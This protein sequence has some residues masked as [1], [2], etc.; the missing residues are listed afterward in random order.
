MRKHMIYLAAG[1]S[2][3]FGA[4]KLLQILGGK[5]LY[6]YG[7]ELLAGLCAE[8]DD[9]TL[10]VV[11]RCAEILNTAHALGVRAVYG[12]DSE[13]GQSF[14]IR[15]GLTALGPLAGTDFVLFAVADQ[16]R[17]T[18]ATVARL[19]DAAAP[20]VETAVASFDG[21]AGSPALFAAALLPEL[22]ALTGD[23]GGRVVLRRHAC[24][25]VRADSAAELCD[26]DTPAA[27]AAMQ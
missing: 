5:P 7:L 18:R 21:Q 6:R 19:L 9:V 22:L 1:S 25:H 2:R 16:P 17:L 24:L 3:R 23:Q 8:R 13:K 27:L 15:A 14:S 4:N 12:T 11:S 20:G 10:T 26:I